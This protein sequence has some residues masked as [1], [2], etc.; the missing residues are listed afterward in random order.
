MRCHRKR[1][2]PTA[3]ARPACASPPDSTHMPD[4]SAASSAAAAAAS[5]DASPGAVCSAPT[6]RS[7]AP[8]SSKNETWCRSSTPTMRSDTRRQTSAS[9]S[10]GSTSSARPCA[11]AS[12]SA[13][14]LC[15]RRSARS[16][17]SRAM[18]SFAFSLRNSSFP[19]TQ[20][21]PR[22]ARPSAYHAGGARRRASAALGRDTAQHHARGDTTD[23]EHQLHPHAP[24]ERRLFGD[25]RVRP[26][27][28]RVQIGRADARGQRSAAR[29]AERERRELPAAA[30]GHAV[31]QLALSRGHPGARCDEVVDERELVQIAGGPCRVQVDDGHVGGRDARLLVRPRDR[32]ARAGLRRRDDVLGV[33]RQGDRL[34]VSA[35]RPQAALRAPARVAQHPDA[36][37]AGQVRAA[38]RGERHVDVA[39]REHDARLMERGDERGV[40]P[41]IGGPD[42]DHLRLAPHDGVAPALEGHPEGRARA[43]GRPRGAVDP[44]QHRDLR[45]GRILDVPH[46]VRAH[47]RPR[48]LGA[49]ELLD[50]RVLGAQAATDRA[51]VR[52]VALVALAARALDGREALEEHAELVRLA[53]PVRVPRGPR[54]EALVAVDRKRLRIGGRGGARRRDALGFEAA[55]AR[56][57]ARLRPKVIPAP[58]RA[59]ER[60]G[61]AIA[62]G[63]VADAGAD[64]HVARVVELADGRL[65][66][67]IAAERLDH[68]ADRELHVLAHLGAHPRE[69]RLAVALGDPRGVVVEREVGIPDGEQRLPDVRLAAGHERG[70]ASLEQRAER[71]D[72]ARARGDDAPAVNPHG[73]AGRAVDLCS[74]FHAI[75]PQATA[76][77]TDRQGEPRAYGLAYSRPMNA[78]ELK[79]AFAEH[80]IRRVKVGG[81][82]VDGILRGKYLALDKFWG[83]LEEPIGFCDVIFGWDAADVLYDNARVTGWHTGYPDTRA[84]IDPSTFR[85]LPWEPHTAAFLMDFVL[86]DGS[87]HPACPRGLLKNVI[88]R[89]RALGFEPVLAAE[90]EF[91]V[92]RE[93]PASLHA[94]GFRGLEPLSPGM[95]GYSWL[96]EG[97]HADLC[98]AILDDM[99]AFGIPIEGLHTET[100][101][102]VYEVAIRYDDAL[103]AADKAALFKTAM[104]VVASRLDCSVTF[105]AKWNR[106]LPG[107]S[108]HV[109]Q[110]LW[111][112]QENAFYDAGADGRLSTVATQY[113]AGQLTLMPELTALISP[114]VNSYK[115]YVPGVWAPL[116]ASWGVENRTCAIRAIPGSAK[117]TRLEH[118]QTAADINPYV[119]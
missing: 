75:R 95:F 15:F 84:R 26:R 22:P 103:R 65:E 30:V 110:S 98:H 78:K 53:R 91:F 100:G 86:D 105:M 43:D 115:R 10:F 94:K 6:R 46:Q 19:L 74:R 50:E 2:R 3:R 112:H 12:Q 39:G 49:P 66:A 69:V 56:A 80:G 61:G 116:N 109:H 118:R 13:K 41:R 83:A 21:A 47:G 36:S 70:A 79:E 54:L 16:S 1:C 7:R 60:R 24:V 64:E 97:Q 101:P 33:R 59:L 5:S 119:A 89:A 67:R 23:P 93:T 44:E 111:R 99:G 40:G 45:G 90:F 106:D 102:G 20:R 58:R 82:D 71:A 114:T 18:S 27:H 107:S 57:A 51:E 96:R 37:P 25:D 11:R 8:S 76:P 63:Q 32:A 35:H 85:V 28:A 81:Y 88:A 87:P 104:K 48:R 31:A 34:H 62:L 92:F 72:V 42:D 117:S 4:A 9:S 52:L 55:A 77:A 108:G 113:L 29:K 17:R 73:G 38:Q 68:R 14:R